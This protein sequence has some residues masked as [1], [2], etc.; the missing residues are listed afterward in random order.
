MAIG[1]VAGVVLLVFVGLSL[2]I[3]L[4]PIQAGIR[5][6]IE[7]A[8]SAHL[9]REVRVARVRLGFLFRSLDLLDV[10]IATH[11]RLEDGVLVQVQAVEIF[12]KMANLVR[13]RLRIG[14]IALRHPRVKMPPL[15]DALKAPSPVQPAIPPLPLGIE[16]VE[17]RDGSLTWHGAGVHIDVT[18]LD[19]DVHAPVGTVALTLHIGQGTVRSGTIPFLLRDLVLKAALD[20]GDVR[21]EEAR[22]TAL[23]AGVQV[24]GTLAKVF[25]EPALDLT[26]GMHGT[27]DGLFPDTPP[28]P[29]RGTFR[30]DGT[31][32]GP[33]ADPSFTGR[34]RLGSG[35]IEDIAMS[36]MSVAVQANRRELRLE[37][38]ALQT[39]S[40]DLTG[41]MTVIWDQLRYDLALHG[42]Q[43]DL[44]DVLRLATGEPPVGGQATIRVQAQGEGTDLTKTQGQAEVVVKE[45][46]LV[47]HPRERG[48]IHIA[49]E[50]RDGRVE[51]QRGEI[52]LARTRLKAEG[53]VTL[54]GD[55]ALGVDIR[56]SEIEDF[57]RL[58]G[59]VPGDVG[60]QAIIQGHLTGSV[61]DPILRGTLEWSQATLLEVELDKVHGPLEVA[62]ARRT[63]T[64]PSLTVLRQKL[65]GLLGV[66]LIL[67]PKPPNRRTLLKYDLTLDVA[68]DVEGP[69]EDL[70]GIFVTGPVPLAGPM[71]LEAR[72]HGTPETLTGQ[73]A[74]A[75]TDVVILDEPWQQGHATVN[76]HVR[77]KK[78]R[79]AGIEL[80]RGS[81]TVAGAFEIHF[82]G[83]AKWEM[84]SN[85]LA[86]QRL[87]LLQDSGLTGAVRIQSL[88]GEGPIGRPRVEAEIAIENLTYG[89]VGLGHGHGNLAWD[90]S[91]HRLTGLLFMP[92]RGY[93]LQAGLSTQPPHS[94][95][96]ILTL[97]K[98]DLV[99]L[100]RSRILHE[101]LPAQMTWTGSGRIDVRGRLNEKWPE[102]ATVDLETAQL[103]IQGQ[104]FGSP[105]RTHL[106]F[107]DGQLTIS[108]LALVGEGAQV[109]VGGTIGEEIDVTI[110]GTAPLILAALV[111]PEVRDATGLLDLDV[112]IQG[113]QALPRYRGHARTKDSSVFF[114][115]HP[116]P[117]EDLVGEIELTETSVETKGL[118]ARWG[119]GPVS[120]TL[121]GTR[122]EQGWGW[123]A[124]F[125]LAE[126][127][128]ER[129]LVI[130]EGGGVKSMAT[131]PLRAMGD[132]TARGGT[133]LLSTLGG[134][135]RFETVKGLIHH[136][137]ALKKALMLVNLSFLHEGPRGEGLPYEK[138][139]ATFD[140]QDG[141]ATTED[142]DLDG[143]VLKAAAVGQL[144]LPYATIDGHLA[145]QPL[146]L[147]D[148]VIK[149]VSSAPIIK[150]TGIGTLLF[151]EKKSVMVI[152]YRVSGP[153]TDPAVEKTATPT[154][155]KGLGGVFERV[156]GLERGALAGDEQAPSE[157]P[158]TENPDT[159]N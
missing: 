91:Q 78:V 74:L 18:G 96:A 125:D 150:H 141:I 67:A 48:H 107:Q 41:N 129:I 62:F 81:E 99:S 3:R 60:G 144:D 87:A 118:Q 154:A 6:R 155:Q 94:Y 101:P 132:I 77:Q 69:V 71:R 119:G 42:E 133:D 80:Q 76:L 15:D 63:L 105:D 142:L 58:L 85:P 4:P 43:V 114:R 66:D 135:V 20:Q 8:L 46:H 19:A 146:Q 13:L 153:V 151:G 143:P 102:W 5:S 53:E 106:T 126:A 140:L 65:R 157:Q 124:R 24:T 121:Q 37:E 138:V 23:G 97:D 21:V 131:G 103:D 148:T 89:D 115:V 35:R 38:F 36:G 100:L 1:V 92:E 93:A 145:V 31:A 88:T 95:E 33:L 61:A 57:G 49:L 86:V 79:L 44:A 122:D 17:V 9:D 152:S 52:E 47:A 40:G 82:D 7:T 16:H 147:T 123:H 54:G 10:R 149:A 22:V 127:R 75:L 12:P 50:G 128:L 27:L 109:T 112:K 39:A 29:L 70:V 11:E 117:F 2:L 134:R 113:P 111:S 104:S 30:L 51:V 159:S 137:F 120:A 59:A 68:G 98:G 64:A 14:R 116:E 26:L 136:T 90:G 28:F 139:T 34:A 84:Q 108:S 73:G 83:N 156:L 55:V 45:F 32:T 56:F 130:T 25:T 158:S 110:L 72:V